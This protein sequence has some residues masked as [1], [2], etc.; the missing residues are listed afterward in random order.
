[1]SWAWKWPALAAWRAIRS[2]RSGHLAAL[3]LHVHV[4]LEVRVADA[5]DQRLGLIAGVEEVGLGGRERFEAEV[6]AESA[7]MR[8]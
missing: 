4:Q 1:M 5:G 3:G 8:A 2:G 7:P 6:D